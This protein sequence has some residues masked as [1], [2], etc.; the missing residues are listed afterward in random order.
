[1]FAVIEQKIVE[2]LLQKLTIGGIAERAAN[3]HGRAI[4]D[5]G[6]NDLEGQL[7]AAVVAQHGIDRGHQVEFGIDQGAVQIK[8]DELDVVDRKRAQRAYH[9]LPV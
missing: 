2:R 3:Q 9:C 6:A 5:V 4:A 8:D 7:L 1:M